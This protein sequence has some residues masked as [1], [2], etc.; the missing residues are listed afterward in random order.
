MLDKT[1]SSFAASWSA[2]VP[3]EVPET[4]KAKVID[5]E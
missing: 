2:V 4:V 3:A 1:L 5:A